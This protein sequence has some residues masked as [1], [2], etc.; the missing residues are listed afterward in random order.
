MVRWGR[1]FSTSK[2]AT[3][4]GINKIPHHSTEARPINTAAEQAIWRAT[5]NNNAIGKSSAP[6]SSPGSNNN[7][8]R[9]M[10]VRETGTAW[11]FRLLIFILAPRNK[12]LSTFFRLHPCINMCTSTGHID[13]NNLRFH[14]SA[15]LKHVALSLSLMLCLS[16]ASK[17]HYNS[18]LELL[19]LTY[20]SMVGGACWVV[21]GTWCVVGGVSCVV[22]WIH[23]IHESST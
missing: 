6:K 19:Y 21:G 14:K 23:N 3:N 8:K 13:I 10:I 16:Q 17:C 2:Y 1:R 9:A 22:Y 12:C 7:A 5:S 15:L 11:C 18:I 20:T 4:P